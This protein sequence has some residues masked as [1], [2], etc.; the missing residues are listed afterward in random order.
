MVETFNF[1]KAFEL[2]NSGVQVTRV[3]FGEN[4]YC[5]VQ[6]P[7]ENSMNTLPYIQMVKRTDDVVDGFRVSRFP[8][9]LSCESMFADDWYVVSPTY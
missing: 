3:Q 8:V 6:K 9:T 1:S 5:R 2:M 7:D 4:I